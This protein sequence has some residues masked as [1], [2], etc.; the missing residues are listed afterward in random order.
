MFERLT[1]PTALLAVISVA[2]CGNGSPPSAAA[3]GAGAPSR[4]AIADG[5]GDAARSP[6]SESSGIEDRRDVPFVPTPVAVVER[7]LE[8]AEVAA[9]DVV[10][11][12][13]SGDGRIVI[14]AAQKHGAR[15]V[16]VEIDPELVAEANEL[17]RAAG[18]SDR[19]RFV[20]GDLF[21]VDLRPATA[22]TLYLLPAVNL[23]LRPRLLE[24]LRP[25]TPVVSHDFSMGDWEPD[26]QE[27]VEGSDVYK[28]VV[29][30]QVA[31]N[32]RWRRADGDAGTA[33]LT[34][35][36]QFLDGDVDGSRIEDAILDGAEV[37][38]AVRATAERYH[39][40]V[41]GG[42]IRGTI[43]RE[44]GGREPWVA[45]RDG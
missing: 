41:D 14:L 23:R 38:F 13:G 36:F 32:W 2:A 12:L 30:A 39:G 34:Q 17:A 16:G 40:R 5:D 9:D 21:E 27:R 18:V 35:R 6:V 22:V 31:G 45:R 3:P 28:W 10:Y 1:L 37:H 33:Q 19:V 7:M 8:L 15:A 29:P 20:E 43:A 44:G 11:D 25:G 42:V 26:H 4:P 24:Q